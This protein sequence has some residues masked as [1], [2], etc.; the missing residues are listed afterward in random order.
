MEM[1][2]DIKSTQE[3]VSITSKEL[4]KSY[5]NL[6]TQFRMDPLRDLEKT[7]STQTIVEDVENIINLGMNSIEVIS[8]VNAEF[9]ETR[10]I[11]SARLILLTKDSLQHVEHKLKTKIISP[12]TT[13]KWI[14]KGHSY[15]EWILYSRTSRYGKAS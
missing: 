2:I 11:W 13:V 4:W 15:A 3:Q 8:E 9:I 5:D 10:L 14:L 1:I 12:S 7:S 6:L